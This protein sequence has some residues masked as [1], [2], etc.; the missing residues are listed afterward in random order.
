VTLLQRIAMFAF[1]LVSTGA[2]AQVDHSHKPWDEL[3]KKH[4]RYIQ[5]GNASRVD[6]AGFMKERA[7]L[8][9]VLDSYQMVS[10]AEFDKWTKPQQQAFLVNAYNAFTIEKILTRYPNIKSIREFGT[11][12][13][14]PWK[15]KFFTLFGQPSYLDQVEHEILRKEGVYDDPRVHVA[16]VCASIGCPMLRNEAFVADRLEAQLE[17][18]M[19]RFMADRTRNRYNPQARRLEISRIFDWYGKDFDKGHKG[20]TSVKA[21]AARYADQLADAPADREAVRSQSVEVS[22]LDYDWALNDAR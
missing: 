4:V 5:G 11:V 9:A 20:F 7:R 16:V 17:D 14:N 19:R 12:F 18:A 10:R 21:A 22:F 6:Y 13:G 2:A 15:D 3:L 8:K 1:V